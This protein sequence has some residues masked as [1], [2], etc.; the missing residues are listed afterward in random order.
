MVILSR[1]TPVLFYYIHT[2]VNVY[3]IYLDWFS[4]IIQ[5]AGLSTNANVV[6]VPLLSLIDGRS[7]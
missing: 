1:I 6:L 3:N 5:N 4:I 7:N 2:L